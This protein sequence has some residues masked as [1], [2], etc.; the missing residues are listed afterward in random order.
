MSNSPRLFSCRYIA[1]CS[2]FL[3]FEL[4]DLFKFMFIDTWAGMQ[5]EVCDYM[6]GLFTNYKIIQLSGG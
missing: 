5:T 3:S 4:F 2:R 1:T 6:P